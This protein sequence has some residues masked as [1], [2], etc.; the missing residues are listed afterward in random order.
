MQQQQL[1]KNTCFYKV[2][3]RA[4][5]CEI[6]CFDDKVKALF[7]VNGGQIERTNYYYRS[8][9]ATQPEWNAICAS[10]YVTRR[11]YDMRCDALILQTKFQTEMKF[12]K[13]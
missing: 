2:V 7:G 5:Q 3:H 10:Y 11:E 4:Y 13:R 6:M 8:D 12:Y 9:L 1:S